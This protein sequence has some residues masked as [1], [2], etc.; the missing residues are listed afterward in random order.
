VAR[1]LREMGYEVVTLDWE[2]NPRPDICQNVLEW[3]YTKIKPGEFEVVFA[4]MP[5]TE[6][7][8]AL[9]TRGR[10]L[11]LADGLVRRTLAAI[12][13]LQP[14]LWFI[15]NPRWGELR[16]REFMRGLPWVDVDY[17]QFS[18]WG[19][20]KPTR[21][22]GTVGGLKNVCCDLRTCTQLMPGT[23]RH[24]EV[25]GGR[26]KR[27]GRKAE[28]RV[29]DRLVRYL[30]T[31]KP[32]DGDKGKA[33]VAK[34]TTMKGKEVDQV[35]KEN[36]VQDVLTIVKGV[37]YSEKL[38]LMRVGM[39]IGNEIGMALE[40]LLDTGAQTNLIRTNLLPDRYLRESEHPLGL[41][42]AS[43]AELCGGTKE[44]TARLK[45][46]G[47]S[48]RGR[49]EP[50][51][52][53]D[54]VFY[55]A[56]I[57]VDAILGFPWLRSH[58]LGILTSPLRMVKQTRFGVNW[59][60]EAWKGK[61]D[62]LGEWYWLNQER[63]L[64]MN[65]EAHPIS[66][67]E[68]EQTRKLQVQKLQLTLPR[69]AKKEGMVTRFEEEGLTEEEVEEFE[70]RFQEECDS[71]TVGGVVQGS[72]DEWGENQGLVEELRAALH[73]DYDHD[74]LSGKFSWIDEDAPIRGP[75]CEAR[76]H[77]KMGT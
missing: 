5:C 71:V 38:S 65:A 15:E 7:S 23:R 64:G 30:L 36:W 49:Q 58:G 68:E 25:L 21:I 6:Y 53:E 75:H 55:E 61:G 59:T 51:W 69:E 22:W 57:H 8:R 11:P 40:I 17:C 3:D 28:F 62:I 76:I 41:K 33:S 48:E 47:Y 19:Y 70:E 74:V 24:R 67:S 50:N 9:A 44:V 18:D 60:L 12:R 37:D 54:A 2:G 14:K 45:F 39:Q 29:P 73:R 34:P 66:L 63:D 16:N 27:L 13:H 35:R 77:L 32:E 72:D 43:G 42:T 31:A 1:V 20:K 10:N 46:Q 4:S 52:I 26:D 56:Q